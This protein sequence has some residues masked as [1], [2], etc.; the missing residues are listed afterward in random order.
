MA[1]STR[2]IHVLRGAVHV[3]LDHGCT[4]GDSQTELQIARNK[5][6]NHLHMS[7]Y[8]VRNSTSTLRS[9]LGDII[10]RVQATLPDQPYHGH[11]LLSSG[12]KKFQHSDVVSDGDH[13]AFAN[14]SFLARP[15]R[16][17]IPTERSGITIPQIQALLDFVHGM[18]GVSE[19]GLWAGSF[20]DE[21]GKAFSFDTFN[22]YHAVEWVIRPATAA[23][24]GSS[25]GTG[26]SYVELLGIIFVPQ[27]SESASRRHHV[28]TVIL[29]VK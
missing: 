1:G 17:Q 19:P 12:M 23:V 7:H 4:A 26:C 9:L 16:L 21:S 18:V 25:H 22:L 14:Y 13:L 5:I 15:G 11:V 6:F 27:F 24:P 28:Q 29:V 8:I 3:V 2:K 20:G 10:E